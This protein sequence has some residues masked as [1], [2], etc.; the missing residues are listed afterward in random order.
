MIEG[1]TLMWF[2][3]DRGRFTVR[4]CSISLFSRWSFLTYFQYCFIVGQQNLFNALDYGG[5]RGREQRNACFV[6]AGVK[7]EQIA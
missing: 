4:S 6:A 5:Q 1:K 7:Q 3:Q 2:L